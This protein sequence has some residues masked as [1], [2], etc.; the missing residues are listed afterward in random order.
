MN[1]PT[2][3]TRELR[4]QVLIARSTLHRVKLHREMEGLRESMRWTRVAARLFSAGS[5][6]MIYTRVATSALNLLRRR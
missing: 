2:E 1:D 5:R 6:A 3:E 4:K